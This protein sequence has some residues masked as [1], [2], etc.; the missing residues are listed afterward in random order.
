MNGYVARHI[1]QRTA[2]SGDVGLGVGLPMS[3]FSWDNAAR[4]A[5]SMEE[6]SNRISGSKLVVCPAADR[7]LRI[8]TRL[9]AS[10]YSADAVCRLVAPP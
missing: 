8:C 9:A 6:G 10:A 1:A 7:R 5:S 2:A 3:S 4:T